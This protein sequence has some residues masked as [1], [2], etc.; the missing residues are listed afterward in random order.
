MTDLSATRTRVQPVSEMN[1]SQM[2]SDMES[3]GYCCIPSYVSGQDLLQMQEFASSVI[4]HPGQ[5]SISLK[6]SEQFSGTKFEKLANSQSFRDI[7][8]KLYEFATGNPSPEVTFYQ[9]LRCLTGKD[10]A[11]ESLVS[12][13]D[14]FLITALLTI[15]IPT[16]GKRGDFLMFPNTRRIRSARLTNLVE[17]MLVDNKISQSVLK[18]VA[19]SGYFGVKRISLVPG[20]LYFFWGYRSIHTNEPCDPDQ[21]RSTALFHFADPHA[22]SQLK[23]RLR[24]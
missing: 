19:Q 2:A 7:F 10:I 4:E 3:S 15:M 12:Y 23:A 14:S 13:Y 21:L 17:K 1:V 5:T 16:K 18:R 6:R 22:D 8:S 9:V 11:K 20:N 24:R